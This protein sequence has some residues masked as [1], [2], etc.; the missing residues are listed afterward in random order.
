MNCPVCGKRS[1]VV[2]SRTTVNGTTR[3]RRHCPKCDRKFTT[4]EA[5]AAAFE[6]T[7]VVRIS[8]EMTDGKITAKL[9]KGCY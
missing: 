1:Q 9:E 2:D 3:R 8:T 6:Q 5:L 4:Y 7:V